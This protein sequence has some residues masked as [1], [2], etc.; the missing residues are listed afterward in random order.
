MKSTRIAVI[1]D[2]KEILENYKELL[3]DDYT[4]VAY[5]DPQEFLKSIDAPDFAQPDLL[6]SDFKMPAITGVE[7]IRRAQK[8]GLNVPSILL[9]GF[10]DKQAILDA[11]DIG[12]FRLLEKPVS[13]DVL[14]AAIDQLLIEHE[15]YKIR[16]EIRTLTSQLRELYST[17]RMAILP[18]IPEDVLARMIIEAPGGT[19]KKKM[20]FDDVLE[21]LEGR[22]DQLLSSEK[23]LNEMRSQKFR[24]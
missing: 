19:V 6:I 1:D 2:E 11:V 16:L 12:V 14:S 23:V 8:K 17:L 4:V 21:T 9:S 18:Y 22:L 5:N 15:V 24:N 10:L 20:S 3:G 13:F 7:M